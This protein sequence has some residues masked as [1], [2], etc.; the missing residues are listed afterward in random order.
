MYSIMR[1]T[2][3][4]TVKEILKEAKIVTRV[5][6]KITVIAP[7]MDE[8]QTKKFCQMALEESGYVSANAKRKIFSDV[9]PEAISKLQAETK[10]IILEIE[11]LEDDEYPEPS[12]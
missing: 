9:D 8:R 2:M 5:K 10:K 11:R 6:E 3:D 4:Y 12:L 7:I 1:D